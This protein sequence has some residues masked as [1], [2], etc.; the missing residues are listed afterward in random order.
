MN[1][2]IVQIERFV[3]EH[4]P[5]FVECAFV[6]AE[7]VRHAFVE[8]VPIVSGA[9]LNDES[10]YPQVGYI[11]CIVEKRWLDELGRSLVR[12]N[13]NKPWS[14]ESVSGTTTLVVYEGQIST[15]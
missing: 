5:G 8:K 2:L 9:N 6:D 15:G 1:R 7:G 14:V 3:D 13:T 4:F 12:I 11:D 10:G